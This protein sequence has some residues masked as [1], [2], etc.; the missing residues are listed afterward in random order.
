MQAV[1]IRYP[2]IRSPT[3]QHQRMTIARRYDLMPSIERITRLL[4]LPLIGN[5]ERHTIHIATQSQNILVIRQ[6]RVRERRQITP[7]VFC[8]YVPHI[9]ITDVGIG[10]KQTEGR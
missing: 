5:M 7:I 10:R 3:Q 9:G 6:N 4:P 2:A 1:E 8:G